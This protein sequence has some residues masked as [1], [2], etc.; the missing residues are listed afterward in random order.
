[1]V[2]IFI[3][4]LVNGKILVV[5]KKFGVRVL[6][7]NATFNIISAISFIGSPCVPRSQ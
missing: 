5:K 2:N 7:F 3:F 6:V 4:V 1:M